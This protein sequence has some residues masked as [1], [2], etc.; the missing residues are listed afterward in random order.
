[1]FRNKY[2]IGF[3][4]YGCIAL[5]FYFILRYLYKNINSVEFDSINF[6]FYYLALSVL[7]FIAHVSFNGIIWFFITQKSRC[8]ID[9]FQ[10]FKFRV[11]SDFGKYIPG[12]VFSYGILLYNYEKRNISK[13]KISIC[14][15][16]EMLLSTMAAVIIAIASVFLLNIKQLDDFKFIFLILIGICLIFLH[17]KVLQFF[18]NLTF[19]ILKK[20]NIQIEINFFTIIR[21]IGLYII[22][23][24]IFG[25]A[26]YFFINSFFPYS[27]SDYLFTTGAFAM[28]SIIGFGAIFAPA[29]LGVREGVLVFTLSIIF[30][31]AVAAIISIISRIWM[32]LGELL[33]FSIVFSTDFI[34]KRKEQK[35]DIYLKG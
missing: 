11:Y 1:M 22:S 9:F 8:S 20:E 23:W 4:K 17:P 12:K 33:I 3:F 6:N 29:G 26:F 7:L 16:Q 18:A 19:R 34:K 32:T 21:V 14:I 10:T 25:W 35:A 30:P 5:I 24:L 31:A 2:I 15:F 28:A 27:V 13:K